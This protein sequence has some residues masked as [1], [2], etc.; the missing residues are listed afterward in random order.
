VPHIAITTTA[1]AP[2][3]PY[4]DFKYSSP[5]VVGNIFRMLGHT[6]ATAEA[7]VGVGTGNITAQDLC[8]YHRELVILYVAALNKG[9]YEWH[10][11][12][13]FSK[14]QG[15][16]EAMHKVIWDNTLTA[17]VAGKKPFKNGVG[18]DAFPKEKDWILLSFVEAVLTGVAVEDEAFKAA[19]SAF[20]DRELMEI[21]TVAVSDVIVI[22]C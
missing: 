2:R 9:M 15:V 7:W 14:K 1:M 17:E 10:H 16:T 4:S 12:V 11:H 8:H 22:P 20:S 18:K 6:P 13:F 3:I 19:K 5:L 21:V